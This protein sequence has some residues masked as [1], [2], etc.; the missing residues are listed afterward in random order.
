MLPERSGF[1]DHRAM[2]SVDSPEF[3]STYTRW[4]VRELRLDV[5]GVEAL[6]DG[7]QVH[8]DDLV[9]LDARIPLSDQF[10]IIVNALALSRDPALGLRVGARMPHAAHGPL[11]VAIASASSLRESI[12]VV[13]R[14]QGLRVPVI[15]LTR[16]LSSDELVL[17]IETELSFDGVGLFL[18]EVMLAAIDAVLEGAIRDGIPGEIR[19]GYPE[20]AHARDYGTWLARPVSFGHGATSIHLPASCLD[21]RNP[22][23]DRDMHA[24]AVLQCERSQLELREHEAWCGRV[25]RLLQ[26]HPGRLWTAE[27]VASALHVSVRTLGRHLRDEGLGYQ[28]LQDRELLRQARVHLESPANTVESVAWM[29]GYHDVSAFRRAFRRWTGT[30]PQQWTAERRA[31]RDEAR[32]T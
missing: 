18:V 30:T 1:G 4:L 12:E 29:L 31:R 13:E 32:R 19:L 17:G 16:R 15:T 10:R 24:Q 7:S 9:R 5:R 28:E 23:A 8:P 3:P 14:F 2:L 26:Q 11:G 25:A 22:F 20:P 21:A 6:L 27:E